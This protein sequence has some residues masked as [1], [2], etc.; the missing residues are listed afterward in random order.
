MHNARISTDK[1]L[2]WKGKKFNN[3]KG[4]NDKWAHKKKLSVEGKCFCCEKT[5]HLA[6]DCLDKPTLSAARFGMLTTKEN[7]LEWDTIEADTRDGRCW[8]CYSKDH[9]QFYCKTKYWELTLN[10]DERT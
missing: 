4:N 10:D 1:K 8:G 5:G 6:R 3:G 2:G 9:L 7:I